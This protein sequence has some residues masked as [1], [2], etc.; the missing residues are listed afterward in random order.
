MIDNEKELST[1]WLYP[2]EKVNNLPLTIPEANIAAPEGVHDSV[3]QSLSQ[4]EPSHVPQAS[5]G[6]PIDPSH[7]VGGEI[8]PE[9]LLINQKNEFLI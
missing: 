3:E 7:I 2:Q 5:E 4:P 6:A 9:T 8:V 1:G